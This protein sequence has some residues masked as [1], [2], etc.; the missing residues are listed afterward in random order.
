MKSR[1]YYFDNYKAFLISIVV[2]GHF[3]L[4]LRGKY[5]SDI[6]ETVFYWIYLFHMPA[7]VFVSGFFSKRYIEK[8]AERRKLAGFLILFEVFK[9]INWLINSLLTGEIAPYS[10]FSES[11]APWYLMGMFWWYLLLPYI[12]RIKAQYCILAAVIMALLIGM[13]KNAN[14]FLAITKAINFFPFFLIGYYSSY[15]YENLYRVRKIITGS[16]SKVGA[17]L[18]LLGVFVFIYI[19]HSFVQRWEP[20]FYGD[21]PYSLMGLDSI[22]GIFVKGIF[23]LIVTAIVFCSLCIIPHEKLVFSYIGGRTLAIYILHIPVRALFLHFNVFSIAG[24][25]VIWIIIMVFIISVALVLL[26][27]LAPLTKLFN[28]AFVMDYSFLFGTEEI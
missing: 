11:S 28:K 1:N 17:S 16:I 19:N 3:L 14:S 21:K 8:G 26:L 7:F 12:E 9:L 5:P 23:L 10:F 18:I 15:Y 2:I 6:F 25:N 27:S 13:D 22:E 4:S 20:L 24:N